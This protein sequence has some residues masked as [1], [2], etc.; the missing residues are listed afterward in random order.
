MD[1]IPEEA[2]EGYECNEQSKH[3]TERLGEDSDLSQQRPNQ[4]SGGKKIVCQKTPTQLFDA[5]LEESNGVVSVGLFEKGA[6][7]ATRSATLSK[8]SRAGHDPDPDPS[9]L[10]L[11]S[12]ADEIILRTGRL[13]LLRSTSEDG[14]GCQTPWTKW[15]AAKTYFSAPTMSIWTTLSRTSHSARPERHRSGLD[16]LVYKACTCITN[17]TRQTGQ[18]QDVR[19][20][21]SN[22]RFTTHHR[23]KSQRARD[24]GKPRMEARPRGR[25]MTCQ[26]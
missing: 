22:A 4:Q 11:K 3:A 13:F 25:T 14:G 21:L 19:M 10:S 12:S 2:V 7:L 9:S 6:L 1:N 18:R 26:P 15:G 24:P 20:R 17:S 8:N 23:P 5:P 16:S